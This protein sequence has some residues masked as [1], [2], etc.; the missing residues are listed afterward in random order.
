MQKRCI[1][2]VHDYF[3]I[4]IRDTNYFILHS[5]LYIGKKHFRTKSLC[6]IQPTHFQ[7]AGFSSCTHSAMYFVTRPFFRIYLIMILVW[8][9]K[10]L[11]FLFHFLDK[12]FLSVCF[13]FYTHWIDSK[14]EYKETTHHHWINMNNI[15]IIIKF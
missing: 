7:K 15:L 9:K 1:F 2:K 5:F 6:L 3:N 14:E 13:I 8:V 4:V 11:I 12:N 10:N